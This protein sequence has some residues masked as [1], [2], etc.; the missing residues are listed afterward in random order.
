MKKSVPCNYAVV[1]FLPYPEAGEFVNVGVVV[2]SPTT[3][4]F[5][6]QLLRAPRVSRVRGFFPEL[7]IDLYKDALKNCA[8]ELTRMR[9]EVGICG[10]T[11]EQIAIDPM[12]G[13]ALFR[14][15]VRARET[16]IR[17]SNAGTAMVHRPEDFL[18]ELYERYVMRMFAKEVE[19]QE[20]I[21]QQRVAATLK[22]H[23]LITRF[24]EARVGDEDYHVT[25]PFVFEPRIGR[26]ERAIKPLN[27]GHHESTKIIEHGEAWL[28]RIR[29]LRRINK[30][31]EKM[32]F[33]I[34]APERGAASRR[35][36]CDEICA[37]LEKLDVTLAS[38]TDEAKVIRFAE[39]VHD[40]SGDEMPLSNN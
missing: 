18:Q 12:L 6:F 1:R 5:D 39:K 31:P 29:R 26:F 3:G 27:L 32:L 36:A 40:S 37:E 19:Y 10:K 24:R 8:T 25:F 20:E 17:F 38:E 11:A 14:E 33:T 7:Q 4:F 15:L 9:N 22:Q 28:T 16:V 34:H 13:V 23:R 35:A 2:H 21:M 30:A